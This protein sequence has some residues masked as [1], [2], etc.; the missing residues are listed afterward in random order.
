[1]ASYIWLVFSRF[2]PDDVSQTSTTANF[3]LKV[4]PVQLSWHTVYVSFMGM[5]WQH[6]IACYVNIKCF[7]TLYLIWLIQQTDAYCL[8]APSQHRNFHI[9]IIFLNATT[10]T[11]LW[12]ILGALI[13]IPPTML[14]SL[15]FQKSQQFVTV[16][17]KRKITESSNTDSSELKKGKTL[18]ATVFIPR[19]KSSMKNLICNEFISF[20]K[21]KLSVLCKRVNV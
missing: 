19:V 3:T 6:L 5:F 14:I 16:V 21:H 2:Q 18:T 15:L 4:G 1:M 8:P 20:A 11:G 10:V 13:V 7:Q 12:L 9:P 17:K